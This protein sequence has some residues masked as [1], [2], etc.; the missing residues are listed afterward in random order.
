MQKRTS[1]IKMLTM[2]SL[3]ILSMPHSFLDSDDFTSMSGKLN[4]D[5]NTKHEKHQFHQDLEENSEEQ[6]QFSFACTD[7]QGTLIFADE[8]FDNGQIRPII[9]IFD[10][11][12]L[13]TTTHNDATSPLQPPLK[14]IFVEQHNNFHLELSSI[15]KESHNEPLQNT[16]M[17]E[18]EASNEWCK[19]SNSTGFSKLWRF[20]QDL[21][22]RSNSDSKDAFIFLN[23]SVPVR[24]NEVKEEN[25]I[26]KNG[27]GKKHKKVLSALEKLYVMNRK[28]K[29]SNKRRS[30][31]PYKQRL[32]G[33]FTNVNGFI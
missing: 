3:S 6:Q 30:F 5:F 13:S 7:H 33:L 31:L 12:I 23:P 20:R 17:M 9:P 8:I 15:S 18:V 21:K 32:V 14:K 29:E 26:V 24:S 11:F 16:I 22:L 1:N 2:Q 19:K 25:I 27:K 28:R 10:Q 4:L